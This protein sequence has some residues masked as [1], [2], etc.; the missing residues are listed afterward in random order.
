MSRF[1]VMLKTATKSLARDEDGSALIE[2]AIAIPVLCVLLFGIYEFSWFFYQ[3]HVIS[4]G[5]RDAARYAA[6]LPAACNSSSPDWPLV[7]A[8]AKNLA[9][10]GSIQGGVARVAGWT[11]TAVRLDC[12]GIENPTDAGGLSVYRGGPVIYVMTAST[13]FR[14]PTLGLFGFLGLP[15]PTISVSHSE[16][17]I[18][19]G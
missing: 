7:Q 2:G 4:T 12:S 11:S 10:T 17:V 19:P 6:R 3:Q 15:S 1:K 13:R 16:R 14:E 8:L 18:G 9:T 5:L